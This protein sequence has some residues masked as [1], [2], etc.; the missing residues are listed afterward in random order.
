MGGGRGQW[1]GEGY[2]MSILTTILS[3]CWLYL[4]NIDKFVE[5][6]NQFRVNVMT[7]LVIIFFLQ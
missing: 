4:N 3:L 6:H 5:D 1:G 7:I 2:I